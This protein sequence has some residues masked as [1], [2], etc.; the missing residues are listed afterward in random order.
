MPAAMAGRVL[1]P[2]LQFL[3]P[4]VLQAVLHSQAGEAAAA[5]AAAAATTTIGPSVTR[6]NMQRGDAGLLRVSLMQR[7]SQL[8]AGLCCA[9]GHPSCSHAA[10]EVQVAQVQQP[11]HVQ[12][13]IACM[14]HCVVQCRLHCSPVVV[15]WHMTA[16]LTEHQVGGAH[17]VASLHVCS[18]SALVLPPMYAGV[19]AASV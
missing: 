3:G 18:A 13:L 9:G 7:Y 6:L 10:S 1:Q 4:A 12:W 2:V 17:V 19:A 8:L 5:T 15:H 16:L 14:P 11:R